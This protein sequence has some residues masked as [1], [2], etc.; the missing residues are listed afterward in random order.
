M[1]SNTI[2]IRGTDRFIR[3]KDEYGVYH[4]ILDDADLY[5]LRLKLRKK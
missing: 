3:D 2:K 4:L 1:K 5:W